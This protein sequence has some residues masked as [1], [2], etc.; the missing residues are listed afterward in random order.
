MPYSLPGK[1]GVPAGAAQTY[2]D[3]DSASRALFFL[4]AGTTPSFV[5]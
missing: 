3:D 1:A 2:R 4:S 5:L